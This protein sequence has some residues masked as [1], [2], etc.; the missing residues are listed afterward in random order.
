MRYVPAA[1]T[2]KYTATAG[3][4][5]IKNREGE[6]EA[7]MFFTSYVVDRPEGGSRPLTFSFNGGPGSASVWLHMGAIGPKRVKMNADGGMPRR[8]LNRRQ[9]RHVAHEV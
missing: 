5:P 7:R 4:M 1:T 8:R 3:M 6:V 9:R 2:I